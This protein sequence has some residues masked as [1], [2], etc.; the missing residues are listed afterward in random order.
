[1]IDLLNSY[2]NV[3]TN[4]CCQHTMALAIVN[5]QFRL[6][7]KSVH[8]LTGQKIKGINHLLIVYQGIS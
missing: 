4:N 1:M 7:I 3:G 5:D 6:N 8:S 2:K